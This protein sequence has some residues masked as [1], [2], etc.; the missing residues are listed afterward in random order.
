MSSTHVPQQPSP[1]DQLPNELLVKILLLLPPPTI[2]LHD[3]PPRVENAFFAISLVSRRFRAFSSD[4]VWRQSVILVPSTMIHLVRAIKLVARW[5]AVARG[6]PHLGL[7]TQGSALVQRSRDWAVVL[8][9]VQRMVMR[10][11]A[12]L[13][14]VDFARFHNL[15][16]LSLHDC[17]V[18]LPPTTALPRLESMRITSSGLFTASPGPASAAFPSLR[19]LALYRPF[20]IHEN[21]VGPVFSDALLGQLDS[22]EMSVENWRAHPVTGHRL[23]SLNAPPSSLPILWRVLVDIDDRLH[24]RDVFL[25]TTSVL[26]GQHL[27]L[28]VEPCQEP[29]KLLSV[30]WERVYVEVRRL[31]APHKHS[32]LRLV[33]VSGVPWRRPKATLPELAAIEALEGDCERRGIALRSCKPPRVEDGPLPDFIEFLRE[34]AAGAAAHGA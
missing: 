32:R 13:D 9:G 2:S 18:F 34:G 4:L 5:P 8:P 20:V 26:Y 23:F 21:P 27:L 15:R 12:D 7:C 3:D 31:V 11:F 24:R 19:H 33:L 14:L 25:P 17:T 28:D 29:D 6:G 1:F 22:F 16:H 10:S 30:R